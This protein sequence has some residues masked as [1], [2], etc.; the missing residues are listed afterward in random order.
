MKEQIKTIVITLVLFLL[1]NIVVFSVLTV[2]QAP[3]YDTAPSKVN[4]IYELYAS[5]EYNQV[6]YNSAQGYISDETEIQI[7]ED[8][9]KSTSMVKLDRIE[10]YS[11]MLL[12]DENDF[13]VLT[14]TRGYGDRKLA[15]KKLV[16][17]NILVY[18]ESDNVYVVCSELTEYSVE[19]GYA[20]IAIYETEN[21]ELAKLL[22]EYKAPKNKGLHLIVPEW[23]YD[24]S[25]F[26][27]SF[28]GRQYVL[29]FIVEFIGAL[30]VVKRIRKSKNLEQ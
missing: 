17:S 4:S 5:D 11:K 10:S 7:I 15:M 30:F 29:S 9:F 21:S 26:P 20:K 18:A 14:M 16:A 8:A 2:V 19:D 6:T 27:E 22:N 23:R 12:L 24:I 1:L 28:D 13:V 25:N 3:Y